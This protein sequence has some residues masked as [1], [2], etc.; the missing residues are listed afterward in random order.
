[1]DHQYACKCGSIIRSRDL[2][3]HLKSKKHHEFLKN[4]Y[5]YEII[6]TTMCQI[7][8]VTIQKKSIRNHER[9][10]GHIRREAERLVI[11]QNEL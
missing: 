8:K 7:C 9:T 2:T 6:P 10:V 3:R 1:M 11:C 5:S 4:P